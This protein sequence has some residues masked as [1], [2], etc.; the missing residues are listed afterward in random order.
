[1]SLAQ[2]RM[3]IICSRRGRFAPR[4]SVAYARL[5]RLLPMRAY[6]AFCR[7][8]PRRI[9]FLLSIGAYVDMSHG[10]CFACLCQAWDDAVLA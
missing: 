7:C 2:V 6:A 3:R 8:A 1:M 5:G 9:V 4:W 10:A